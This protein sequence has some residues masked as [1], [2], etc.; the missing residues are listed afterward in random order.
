[1]LVKNTIIIGAA[2]FLNRF[3]GLISTIIVARILMPE[4]YGIIATCMLVQDLGYRFTKVGTTQNLISSKDNSKTFTDSLLLQRILVGFISSVLVFLSAPYV[5]TWFNDARIEDALQVICW[6]FLLNSLVN[7]NNQIATKK[8]NFKPELAAQVIG[9]IVQVSCAISIAYIYQSYWALVAGLMSFS[10]MNLL[11]SYIVSKPYFL[12]SL[13]LALTVKHFAYSKWYLA[14]EMVDYCNAKL[15]QVLIGKFF[16]KTVLGYFSV[17]RDLCFMFS[18]EISA[19]IDKSNLSHLSGKLNNTD[20][21]AEKNHIILENLQQIFCFKNLT[22]VP[23]YF[24]FIFYPDFIIALIFGENWLGMAEYFRLFSIAALLIGFNT[25][26]P[27][28]FDSI[29][30]PNVNFRATFITLTFLVLFS[31]P[32]IQYMD[33]RIFILGTISTIVG[34][35]IYFLF[36]L[37]RI[38]QIPLAQIIKPT[39]M[40]LSLIS[41][42]AVIGVVLQKVTLF[43]ILE[44]CIYG[45]TYLLV[46]YSVARIFNNRLYL[47]VFQLA[48]DKIKRKSVF[49]R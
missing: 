29:R 18:L 44:M 10:A 37:S 28:I 47:S 24:A 6:I 12:T 34:K 5:A 16:D 25:T 15:S 45:I 8:N 40:S 9:K 36:N 3:L 19:A 4:D 20:T 33:A 11:S 48:A 42:S 14:L 31:I 21:E 49:S 7:F 46:V 38:R 27:T 26:F 1:M 2:R 30:R 35:Q 13:P 23:F 39:M 22:I 41:F 32:A 43:P 17:G